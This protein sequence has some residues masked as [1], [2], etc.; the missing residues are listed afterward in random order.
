MNQ[1]IFNGGD[2]IKDCPVDWPT[3][4]EWEDAANK[5]S[6]QSECPI[7]RFDCGFKLDFDGPIVS[8][9]SRFYPPKTHNRP[10]W[11]GS[12]RVLVLGKQVTEK[13]FRCETLQDLHTQVVAFRDEY[14]TNLTGLL[15]KLTD[16]N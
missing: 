11:D 7:W 2:P 14:A 13:A 3:A 8:F 1:I 9:E 10:K 4:R 12:V 15:A 6:K 5:G 16:A